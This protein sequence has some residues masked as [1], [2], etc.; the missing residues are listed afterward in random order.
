MIEHFFTCPYCWG[1]IS[2]LI[3]NSVSSQ[4]YIEDCEVCCRPIQVNLKFINLEL[5]DFQVSE[6]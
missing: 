2:M 3:D 6:I 1:Q 5:V 4:Q